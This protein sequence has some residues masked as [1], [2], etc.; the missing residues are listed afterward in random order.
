M[1]D[2]TPLP[3]RVEETFRAAREQ[4]DSVSG[5]D[6]L[7]RELEQA[8][9]RLEQPMRVA[10]VGLIKAG[11]ST[12]MNALLGETVV[13]M[14]TVEATFN[15]NWLLYGD[16]PKL[17]VHFK[18]GRP[19]EVK[20]FMELTAL[21]LRADANRDYLLSIRYITV[22][23]PNRILQIFNL[24]DT[25]GLAS[26]YEDDSQ[27]TK[28]FI[29]LHGQALTEATQAEAS[30]ADA[31]LY[32]FSQSLATT[33]AATVEEFLTSTTGRATP[34]NAIGVLTKVDFYWTG[35]EDPIEGGR[36]IARRLSEHPKVRKLFYA[37][38]PVCGLLAFGAQTLTSEEYQTLAELRELPEER[39]E[40]L[41]R[42]AARFSREY[43]DVAIAPARRAEVMNRLGR[44]GVWL[45]NR[46][47]RDGIDSREALAEELVR[48]S[49]V[50]ALRDLIVSH[51]GNRAYLIK[52]GTAL[53]QIKRACFMEQQ[54]LSETERP[55]VARI[56]GQFEEIEEHEQSFQE[57]RVLRSYYEGRTGFTPDE[58]GQLLE[59]TG[60]GGR[61]C[62]ERLGLGERA[63]I[64]EMRPVAQERIQYWNRRANDFLGLDSQTLAAAR[65][66]ARSYER[67]LYRIQKAEEYLYL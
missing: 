42:D 46:L 8:Q 21:T 37:I 5:L 32:L 3:R 66:M 24:I 19:P 53:Q 61:S 1:D 48:R 34:I 58:V 63:T 14:G 45:A 65:V 49:G 67:I 50:P 54:R 11:K 35:E 59:V 25:P 23:Y 51:F 33:D 6:A 28:D 22:A 56:G 16:N 62:G 26:F 38:V 47:L 40:R 57:L 7:R 36:R 2:L 12:M 52:L 60:E 43:P 44:Y 27:N 13:A 20:S 17:T 39:F 15:I 64:A 41:I 18:D 31:V 10:I 30:Q 4:M 29:Q 9:E 55:V